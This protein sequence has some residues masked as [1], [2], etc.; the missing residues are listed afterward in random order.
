MTKRFKTTLQV[1]NYKPESNKHKQILILASLIT[2]SI[3]IGC[4]GTYWAFSSHNELAPTKFQLEQLQKKY[5]ALKTEHEALNKKYAD[6]QSQN[7]KLIEKNQELEAAFEPIKK[8]NER[9]TAQNEDTVNKN[10]DLN[11]KLYKA[12][13]G[14]FNRNF[15]KTCR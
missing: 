2:G 13:K 10:S 15:N 5:S 1:E 9:L 8:E 4:A 12:C 11:D 3:A 14:I 6:S 7:K